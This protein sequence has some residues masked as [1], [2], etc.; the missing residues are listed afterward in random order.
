MYCV[1]T[2]VLA[3]LLSLMLAA[4]GLGQDTV[5][6]R[7]NQPP[8]V[9]TEVEVLLT[10]R[11]PDL[12]AAVEAEMERIERDRAAGKYRNVRV[13]E[14][15]DDPPPPRA[16][17]EKI[18]GG[19][20]YKLRPDGWWEWDDA[21]NGITHQAYIARN[22]PTYR[23]A[24]EV[25]VQSVPTGPVWAGTMIQTTPAT[26]VGVPS[27]PFSV[28]T[29]T[30]ATITGARG[31]GMYGATSYGGGCASGNCGSATVTEITGP[32]GGSFRRARAR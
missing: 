1:Y 3:I 30:G 5:R 8:P 6:V 27:T 25:T 32:F 7:I 12:R 10:K 22:Y 18:I 23:S 15:D 29:V 19:H 11:T 31:V 2:S 21:R 28:G 13:R 16:V 9:T 4:C 14:P 17:T 20:W 24:P 26:V